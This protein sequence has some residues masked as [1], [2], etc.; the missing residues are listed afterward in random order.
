MQISVIIPVF[1]GSLFIQRCLNSVFSQ[2]L[3]A[4][5]IIV[6]DDGSTDNTPEIL[7]QNQPA[8]RVITQTNAGRSMARNAG[9]RE[10]RGEYVAFLDADDEYLPRH[11]EQLSTRLQKEPAEIAFDCFGDPFFTDSHR[12]PA[13]PQQ[14]NAFHH[15]AN[16][17]IWIPNSMV[18]LGWIRTHQL[19]FAPSLYLA[20]DAL[21]FWQLILLGARVVYVRERGTRI[22]V[23]PDH[24]ASDPVRTLRETLRAYDLLEEFIA[25]RGLSPKHHERKSLRQGRRHAEI[26]SALGTWREAIGSTRLR[27]ITRL[28]RFSLS[29]SP[30]RGVDRLR[31][32]LG[33]GWALCPLI[34]RSRMIERAT[35]GFTAGISR[36]THTAA[37]LKVLVVGQTP[38]PYHGQ[39]IA[40]EHF[41][42]GSY[43]R[44]SLIHVRMEFSRASGEVGQFKIRKIGHLLQVL[45][46]IIVMRVRHGASTLYYPPAGPSCVPLARDLVLLGLTRWLFKHVVFHFHATGISTLYRQQ[47]M[48]GQWLFRRAYFKPDLALCLSSL[49]TDDAAF[50]QARRIAIIPNGVPDIKI[51]AS[52]PRKALVPTLLYAGSVRESKGVLVLIEACRL[53]NGTTPAFELALMGSPYPEPFGDDVKKAIRIAGLTEQATLLGEQ[54]G[55]AKTSAFAKAAVFCFPSFYEAETF[56]LVL[57]EAMSAGLP[58]VATQWRG[59]S[60]IVE[61][62]INGFLVPPYDPEAL[63]GKISLLLSDTPLRH[64]MGMA[65]R[66]M[67]E[68]RYT[69]EIFQ[70]NMEIALS[71]LCK[72]GNP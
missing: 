4:S 44:I 17:Q 20:E 70:R 51:H 45:A 12:L 9:L 21:F 6:V 38:P 35:F 65:S 50:I 3:P 42:K 7:R 53:L 14:S 33:V 69:L 60:A 15:L 48:L 34:R 19:E 10:A 40:I 41:L 62:G 24:T 27:M 32:L 67:Y 22:G 18:R 68:D 25:A 63:A 29:F 56:P 55:T 57:L 43:R 26:M 37:P 71:S 59:I 16:Y 2:T 49:T 13:K 8:I 1:N 64:R 52:K 23:R 54:I 47:G 58:I 46:N 72:A 36:A 66:K 11:L 61:D 30:T 39:A 28:C 5:E 31:C